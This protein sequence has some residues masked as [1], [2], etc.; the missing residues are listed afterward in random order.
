MT[1]TDTTAPAPPV[2]MTP[3]EVLAELDAVVG[4]RSELSNQRGE[5]A[6]AQAE[7]H[8]ERAPLHRREAD[9]WAALALA[10]VD[11]LA[12]RGLLVRGSIHARV[13]AR[14]GAHTWDQQAERA[15]ARTA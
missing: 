3:A 12:V 8:R 13:Y 15:E 5:T 7:L 11:D 6:S 9:A 2:A 1:T 4:R 10:E 14:Q